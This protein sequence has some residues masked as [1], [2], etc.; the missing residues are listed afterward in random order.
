MGFRVFNL[1]QKQRLTQL[2]VWIQRLFLLLIGRVG[3]LW[4][5]NTS[6]NICPP[7]CEQRS[8][9]FDHVLRGS[10]SVLLRLCCDDDDE[11]S[12]GLAGLLFTRLS[13]P[14]NT[15]QH[16]LQL[17]SRTLGR[18][19][20]VSMGT[21]EKYLAVGGA[22]SPPEFDALEISSSAVLY[23]LQLQQVEANRT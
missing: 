5:R 13:A 6:L 12:L 2:D 7:S 3:V 15:Q 9:A 14:L 19:S 20:D 18:T 17:P 1:R 16:G 21:D 11:D 23:S 10:A 22:S 4:K 8:R